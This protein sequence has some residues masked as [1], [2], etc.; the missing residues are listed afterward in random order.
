MACSSNPRPR[1]RTT[2]K[3]EAV[4]SGPISTYR[5]RG[6]RRHRG[7]HPTKKES[8]RQIVRDRTL[9]PTSLAGGRFEAKSF[10]YYD[11]SEKGPRKMAETA[12]P[13][14]LQHQGGPDNGEYRYQAR[15]RRHPQPLPWP[16]LENNWLT[17]AHR[18]FPVKLNVAR[19]VIRVES[20]TMPRGASSG[21][22]Q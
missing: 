17:S 9:N 11:V 10:R 18:A 5:G 19:R 6:T 20:D 21:P 12:L 1:L 3:L 8:P 14:V 4:P 7:V 15:G 13:C 22:R 2:L 16:R